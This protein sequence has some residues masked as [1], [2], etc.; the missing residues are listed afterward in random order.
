MELTG[1]PKATFFPRADAAVLISQ[2]DPTPARPTTVAPIFDQDNYGKPIEAWSTHLESR[3]YPLPREPYGASAIPEP[4]SCPTSRYP[5]ARLAKNERLRLSMLWYYTRDILNEP[6]LL[7]GLHQKALMAKETAGWE[8]AVIGVLDVNV[9]IRLAT[10]GLQL[11]I[12]P[13]GETLCAHTV[14]QP[15]GVSELSSMLA[16]AADVK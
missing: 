12:L 2:H 4:P 8:F 6:E 11:A 10:V 9:Y 15:P 16:E 3:I 7:A 14:T 13:R 5:R 1:R